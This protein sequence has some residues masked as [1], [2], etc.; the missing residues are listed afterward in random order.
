MAVSGPYKGDKLE[1]ALVSGNN[2]MSIIF[3]FMEQKDHLRKAV[4]LNYGGQ[5][6]LDLY[7]LI[8]YLCALF[9]PLFECL[10]SKTGQK[11][12]DALGSE[13]WVPCG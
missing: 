2:S 5:Q 10:F 4:V 7:P 11:P 6:T 8:Y 12:W 9:L 13:F 1:T 3:R